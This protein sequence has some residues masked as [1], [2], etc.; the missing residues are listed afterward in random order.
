MPETTDELVLELERIDSLGSNQTKSDYNRMIAIEKE[1]ERREFLER[2]EAAT[3]WQA[4]LKKLEEARK[5]GNERE[6]E[7]Q[8]FGPE[9]TEKSTITVAPVEIHSGPPKAVLIAVGIIGLTI[10]LKKFKDW[11]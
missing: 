11:S 8:L 3:Q 6:V 9:I 1:L 2:P 7:Q 5:K 10:V 4:D